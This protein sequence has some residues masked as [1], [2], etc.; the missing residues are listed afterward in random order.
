[1]VRE[2][3][4]VGVSVSEV[5]R[6]TGHDRRTVR[7]IRDGDAHP[8]SRRRLSRPSKLARYESYLRARVEAGVLNATKLHGEKGRSLSHPRCTG[9]ALIIRLHWGILRDRF[10]GLLDDR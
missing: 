8:V 6:R 3:L 4:R 7:R 9:G 10:W 2:L 5:A 1:M